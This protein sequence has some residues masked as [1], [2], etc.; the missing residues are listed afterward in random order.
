MVEESTK[1]FQC[2]YLS[3]PAQIVSRKHELGVYSSSAI[4]QSSVTNHKKVAFTNHKFSVAYLRVTNLD[5]LVIYNV[6]TS[7]ESQLKHNVSQLIYTVAL[8]PYF[9]SFTFYL[10]GLVTVTLNFSKQEPSYFIH[11]RI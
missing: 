3:L 6:K 9:F 10:T 1:N 7:Q 11:L 4:Q 2:V 5:R 8:W